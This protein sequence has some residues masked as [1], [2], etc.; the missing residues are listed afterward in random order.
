M[1]QLPNGVFCWFGRSP[2]GVDPIV[3]SHTQLYGHFT[4]CTKKNN[5]KTKSRGW[6]EETDK[7]GFRN[8]NAGK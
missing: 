6:K 1:K 2:S 4:G 5:K 8:G 7:H 3:N